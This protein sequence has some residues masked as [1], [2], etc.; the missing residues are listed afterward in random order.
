MDLREVPRPYTDNASSCFGSYLGH[1]P[2][3]ARAAQGQ[4]CL[5]LSTRAR[6]F[7]ELIPL[8]RTAETRLTACGFASVGD[9]IHVAQ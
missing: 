8:G 5:R 4:R 7:R 1:L 3:Q 9:R 6:T 2:H